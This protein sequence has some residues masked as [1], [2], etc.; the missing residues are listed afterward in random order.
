MKSSKKFPLDADQYPQSLV[1]AVWN[2]MLRTRIKD[3]KYRTWYELPYHASLCHS[4][5]RKSKRRCRQETHTTDS[6]HGFL[7]DASYESAKRKGFMSSS[8]VSYASTKQYREEISF[9]LPWS[10]SKSSN[11]SSSSKR[12]ILTSSAAAGFASVAILR[13]NREARLQIYDC[14]LGFRSTF[15]GPES[16]P[17]FEL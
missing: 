17:F 12:S 6:T 13:D 3:H 9:M 4:L 16:P 1:L 11:S 8:V 2:P 15:R 10:I 5:I 14:K 7:K